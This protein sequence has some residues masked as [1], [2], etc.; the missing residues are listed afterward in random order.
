MTAGRSAACRSERKERRL[1]APGL[2]LRLYVPGTRSRHAPSP[3]CLRPLV[4]SGLGG[5]A[6]NYCDCRENRMTSACVNLQFLAHCKYHINISC[7]NIEE[8]NPQRTLKPLEPIGQ[9]YRAPSVGPSRPP[10]ASWRHC[11]CALHPA[12][13]TCSRPVGPSSTS[14]G[15]RMSMLRCL[16]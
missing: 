14:L 3:L 15:S 8:E 4:T 5:T 11:A 16:F 10:S 9:G 12:A 6:S 1:Q 2:T 7:F 13:L